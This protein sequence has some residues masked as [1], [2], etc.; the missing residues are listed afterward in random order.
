MSDHPATLGEQAATLNPVN[1]TAV[2]ETAAFFRRHLSPRVGATLAVWQFEAKTATPL[3]VFFVATMGR[4]N[5]ALAMGLV[6][7]FYSAVLLFLLE[8]QKVMDELRQWMR[9]R[10]WGRHYLG[11]AERPDLVGKVQRAGAV[12]LTVMVFGPFWRAVTYHLAR[13][14]RVPAYVLSVGGSI[15]HSLFWTGLVVGGFYEVAI[16]PGAAWLRDSA[17][18]PAFGLLF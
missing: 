7:A 3:A 11:I 10:G 9:H 13:V 14:P 5:G 2:R 6:M 8:G 4:W 18:S 1:R 12:P 15:P 17:L 16:E